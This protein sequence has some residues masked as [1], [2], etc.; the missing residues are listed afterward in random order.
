MHRDDSHT[1]STFAGGCGLFFIALLGVIGLLLA[2]LHGGCTYTFREIDDSSI[3]V[4][5]EFPL[6][7]I[8]YLEHPARLTI[9]LK[10]PN[11]DLVHLC[12]GEGRL[13]SDSGRSYPLRID[14]R[15]ERDYSKS[16]INV[17]VEFDFYVFNPDLSSKINELPPDRYTLSLDF[18]GVPDLNRFSA[19]FLIHEVRTT[20]KF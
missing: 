19:T 10:D 7:S 17:W 16:K 1:A 8:R 4:T 18:Y 14:D 2:L 9:K 11:R 5:T 3:T 15:D 12:P 20:G 13:T 6:H